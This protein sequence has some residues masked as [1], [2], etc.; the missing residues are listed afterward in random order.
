MLVKRSRFRCEECGKERPCY[1]IVTFPADE[2]VPEDQV[3][4]PNEYH[5]CL[6]F[7]T[8]PA[9]FVREGLYV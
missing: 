3:I 5:R 1:K 7:K 2:S 4:R 6:Q 9:L 8:R